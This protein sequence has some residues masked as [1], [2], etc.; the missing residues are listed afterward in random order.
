MLRALEIALKGK[1]YKILTALNPYTEKRPHGMNEWLDEFAKEVGGRIHFPAS[2]VITTNGKKVYAK[3]TEDG[4]KDFSGT[5][6]S[7][8]IQS[9]LDTLISE[10]T[11][12]K[13][14][15]FK[16]KF[17]LTTSIK[18]PPNTIFDL[19]QAELK[20]ADGANSKIIENKD[21]TTQ[22]DNKKILFGHI[23]GNK[24]NQT[25]ANNGI[26]LL[27]KKIYIIG[28]EITNVKGYAIQFPYSSL[29]SRRVFIL[30]NNIWNNEKGAIKGETIVGAWITGNNYRIP[31]QAKH[32]SHIIDLSY[33]RNVRIVDNNIYNG[34]L[35]GIRL[36]NSDG[37]IAFNRVQTFDQHGIIIGDSRVRCFQ[38]EITNFALTGTALYD[39]IYIWGSSSVDSF[40]MNNYI[41]T[42]GNLRY[43][44]NESAGDYNQICYNRIK[45]GTINKTGANTEVFG[46]LGFVTENSGTATFNGGTTVFNIPHGLASTPSSYLVTPASSDAKG[47]FYITADATN[48]VVTYT[49][50][51]PAGTN[52]VKLSW[53][54][55]V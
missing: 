39:G 34:A 30:D 20:L 46:N 5:D 55:K 50:A 17:K 9:A 31:G 19:A 37:V 4:L 44:I 11:W 47:E 22:E 48:I 16:G 7:T 3:A 27:G 6:A 32:S 53:Q 24:A 40:Y 38:N 18:M 45:Q 29:Y 41:A 42:T 51:P 13:T 12:E 1:L 10:R 52:N 8:V 43:A 14:V 49:T 25:V 33:A 15:T 54:A 35:A 26:V 36:R 2:Y 28:V 21:T 23:D